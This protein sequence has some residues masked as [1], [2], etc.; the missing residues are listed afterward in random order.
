MLA[1]LEW[2][3]ASW[4]A[5]LGP[6]GLLPL[7]VVLVVQNRAMRRVMLRTVRRVVRLERWAKSEGCSL[8]AVPPEGV[9]R[10]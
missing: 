4:A 5:W 2:V 3:R 7:Y 1:F 10:G 8:A 9:G 6:P